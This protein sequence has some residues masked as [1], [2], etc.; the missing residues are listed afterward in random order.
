MENKIG[1]NM[2]K[3]KLKIIL[4]LGVILTFSFL[5]SPLY[6]QELTITTDKTEYQP[7]EKVKITIQNNQDKE[8]AICSV[9]LFCNIGNFST[10]IEKY[11]NDKWG[12]SVGHCVWLRQLPIKQLSK[13][14]AGDVQEYDADTDEHRFTCYNLLPRS[15]LKLE[16]KGSDLDRNKKL[17]AV[18]YLEKDK[19]PI[20]S[21]EFTINSDLQ[22]RPTK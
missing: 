18:Y 6:S 21:N 16:I 11:E 10:T 9:V 7:E 15:S 19:M 14:D 17:R 12:F 1:E 13:F 8:I 2:E 5:Q 20:Y 3:K 4:I 22:N